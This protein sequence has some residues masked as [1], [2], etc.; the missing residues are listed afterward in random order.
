[1]KNILISV[2]LILSISYFEPAYAEVSIWCVGD[3]E[4]IAPYDKSEKK[5]LFWD[6]DENVVKIYGARNEYVSFQV[7]IKALNES[8]SGVTVLA[9]EFRGKDAGIIEASN[10]DL[11]KEHYLKVTVPSSFDGKPVDEAQIGVYPTQMIPFRS[12]RKTIMPFKIE[13]DQNQPIWVDIYIPE[14]AVAGEYE[15]VFTIVSDG[16][17]PVKVRVILTVWDFMLPH[18][19]HFRTYIYYGSEQLRWAF[20]Y[21]DSGYPEFRALEDKFFQMAHQHRL[22]L[23]PNLEM[24][25]GY[26]KFEK[27]WSERGRGPYIDGS[28]YT[29]RVGKKTPVN[30]WVIQIDDFDHEPEYQRLGKEALRFFA[31]K[32]VPDILMLYVY[33]EPCS[34]KNYDFIRERCDWVHK[35][36]GKKLPC[37]VTVPIKP[38]ERSWGSLVG[39]VDIW[40]SGDSVLQDVRAR[41]KAGDKI[42]TYNMG[43]GGG[44]YVDT[45][46]LAGRTHAWMGWK[47][48]IEG[49]MFWDSCYWIDTHSL[50]DKNG[51]KISGGEINK[52]P[53]QYS[54]NVWKDPMTYDQMRRPGYRE[55]DAMR[56]NGDGVLFYPGEYIGL[57]EPISSFIMK[58][59]RRGLQDYEYMWLARSMGKEKEVASIVDSVIIAPK[60][61][62]KDVNAWY[63]A[64]MELAKVILSASKGAK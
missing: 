30:T 12:G 57:Q 25:W 27:Y 64:R 35:A 26:D 3:C 20:G 45:S 28:A 29:K 54:T 50:R 53:A 58:S 15:S 2:F 43:W 13:K 46:G 48:D 14:D 37:M 47:F 16:K 11:F 33:D 4:K 40:N 24:E 42:W 56:L 1:M 31:E 32:N 7:I 49:W 62:N 34:K 21:N 18:E 9:D 51:N 44:P 52:N 60:K 17:E 36:L 8:L 19:T 61:W 22:V 63:T 6:G 38:P 39:Y 41:Q 10:I 55:S 59:L 5:N 23:C